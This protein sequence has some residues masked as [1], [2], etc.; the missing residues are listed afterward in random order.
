MKQE[1]N[2]TQKFWDKQVKNYDK[3][4]A[5]FGPAFDIILKNTKKYLKKSDVLFDFGCA[6]GSKTFQLAP[7]V[8]KVICQDISPKMIDEAKKKGKGS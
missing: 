6:T 8:K 3:S 7:H 5:Q 2:K 4:E 1:V